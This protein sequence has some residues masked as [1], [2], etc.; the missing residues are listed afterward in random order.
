MT[1]EQL[2]ATLSE[3]E[4]LGEA[5]DALSPCD[6]KALLSESAEIDE[7]EG[8][9]DEGAAETPDETEGVA[10]NAAL[11]ALA[12]K[13]DQIFD[14]VAPIAANQKTERAQFVAVLREN[15][16]ALTDAEADALTVA[17]LS[18]MCAQYDV[19][20]TGEADFSGRGMPAGNRRRAAQSKTL[21]P[22]VF[23]GEGE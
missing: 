3:S 16:V 5:L 8:L 20:E 13:V 10:D 11:N 23:F 15:G 17:S 18:A 12:A 4:D 1:R 19:P 21:D 7:T 9:E 22:P 14:I 6:R 2:I